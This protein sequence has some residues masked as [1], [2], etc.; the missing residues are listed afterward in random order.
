MKNRH[1]LSSF[2]QNVLKENEIHVNRPRKQLL[3]FG[4]YGGKYSH[5]D[6]LLPLLPPASHYCEPFGGSAAVLLNRPPAPIE[7][8][9]DLDQEV[10]NFFRVL[11]TKRK[12]LIEAIALTPY[13]RAE[14]IQAVMPA[15]K[16]LSHL[17]RAR[18]FYIRARQARIGLAQTARPSNWAYCR[19]AGRARMSGTVSR[20]LHS[21]VGLEH[22]AARLLRVQLECKDA[23]DV[24]ARYDNPDTLFYCDP[25]YPAMSRKNRKVYK[26]ELDDEYH[27]RLADRLHN[28]QGKAALS[29]YSCPL[30]DQ[31][32]ADW[33]HVEAPPRWSHAA[34]GLRQEVVWMNYPLFE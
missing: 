14:F 17:E 20:W 31:L 11:R 1:S 21:P 32:Y 2:H 13:S 5:L 8:Y 29:G 7:T 3:A 28:I 10:V 18:R 34:Q 33:R 27:K 6:W 23:L 25:P 26:F 9:N 19:K 4:W 30:L 16:P 12:R 24:I 15:S 22:V